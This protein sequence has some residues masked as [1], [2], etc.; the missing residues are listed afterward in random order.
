MPAVQLQGRLQCRLAHSNEWD[1]CWYWWLQVFFYF[2]VWNHLVIQYLTD[3]SLAYIFAVILC[4]PPEYFK[5][6]LNPTRKHTVS[7]YVC[8]FNCDIHKVIQPSFKKNK[9]SLYRSKKH[10]QARNETMYNRHAAI[11]VL[12]KLTIWYC[13]KR[14]NWHHFLLESKFWYKSTIR[15]WKGLWSKPLRASYQT[16]S[17][18]S[19]TQWHSRW[20]YMFLK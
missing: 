4:I 13:S 18:K 9:C 3:Y 1:V 11:D 15:G 5:A 19:S 14:D 20:F 16:H 2:N 6:W 12:I 10:T 8:Y 7:Y 17:H